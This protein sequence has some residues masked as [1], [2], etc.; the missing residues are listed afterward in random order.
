MAFLCDECGE[1]DALF[2]FLRIFMGACVPNAFS[3]VFS[4]YYLVGLLPDKAM[5]RV[6]SLS[7]SVFFVYALHNTSVLAFC[8]EL[9]NKFALPRSFVIVI[10]PFVTFGMCY[11]F[12]WLVRKI[13]PQ[14]LVLLCGGRV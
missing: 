7:S 14:A 12:Y 3:G 1:F 11:A 10:V 6:T 2:V 9:M 5:R 4:F 13:C 8:G